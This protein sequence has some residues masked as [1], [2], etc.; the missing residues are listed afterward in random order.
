MDDMNGH[1]NGV[2]NGDTNGTNGEETICLPSARPYKINDFCTI[3]PPLTRKGIGPGLILLL[4]NDIDLST[5]DKTLDPPPLQKWAEEGYAVAQIQ[6]AND[7]SESNW[8]ENSY[9]DSAVTALKDLDTCESTERLGLISYNIA[10][11]PA[12]ISAIDERDDIAALSNYGSQ[13]I[14][15][16]K[17]QL[18]HFTGTASALAKPPGDNVKVFEYPDSAPYFPIPAHD[19]FRS[20]P[21]AVSHTR[22]LTF[23]KPLTGGPY[24]DLEAIWDEH[25]KFEFGERAVEKTMGTMVQ[26]PYVNHVP[27]ITGG[28]GRASLTQFYRHHFVFNNPADT[29]LE[30]VSRTVGIDR[31]IDEFVFSFTHDKEIDWILPGVPP[32]GKY[33]EIPFT[34][35]INIRGDRLYHEHIGWDQATLLRQLGLMP[36]Y[37]PFPYALPDGRTPAAGKRF[38]YKVPTAGIET[39]KKLVDE[40]SVESNAMFDFGIR[41]VDF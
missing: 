5:S 31:V 1:T 24:F 23:L 17:P 32:T 6:L 41:E 10:S 28:I 2:T 16:V 40:R 39:A 3:Q 21:A 37:L 38:E 4:P 36:E 22:S 12:M 33:V 7:V 34:G 26:E 35:V 29:A 9:L 30:L 25:T 8:K 11:N 14:P 19:N 27:T 15:S 20:A 18:W 13:R